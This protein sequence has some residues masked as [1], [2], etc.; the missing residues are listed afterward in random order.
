MESRFR[1]TRGPTTMSG[2]RHLPPARRKFSKSRLSPPHNFITFA[3]L[4]GYSLVVKFQ[5]SK[6]AMRVRFP[7]PAL[8]SDAKRGEIRGSDKK[9]ERDPHGCGLS[10]AFV[11]GDWLKTSFSAPL[12]LQGTFAK[13][14]APF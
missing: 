2:W 1:S 5:S 4:R 8:P 9:F 3:P 6:L 12:L 11:R 14:R 7:L 13:A 10:A